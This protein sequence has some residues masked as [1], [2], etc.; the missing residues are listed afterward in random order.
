PAEGPAIP[1]PVTGEGSP[2]GEAPK[3]VEVSLG[4]TRVPNTRDEILWV[5][6]RN[7]ANTL[8]F[9]NYQ[10]FMDRLFCHKKFPRPAAH[11]KRLL[12]DN[13]E[14]PVVEPF[15]YS[16]VEAYRVLKYATEIFVMTHCGVVP[17]TPLETCPR[18]DE[19]R[20]GHTLHGTFEKLWETYLAKV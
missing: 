11:E 4:R 15:P 2:P 12:A 20:F 17:Q 14:M 1:F 5:V 16:S 18:D 9:D 3:R 8:G 19:A 6:I 13:L 10:K 7:S